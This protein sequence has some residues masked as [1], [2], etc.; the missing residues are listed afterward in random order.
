MF[1]EW[2]EQNRIEDFDFSTRIFPKISERKFWQND[3]L[4][5]HIELAENYLDFNWPAIKATDYIAFKTEKSRLHHENIYFE[6]RCA[7]HTLFL[8]EVAEYKGRFLPQIV[9]GI[10]AICE[11]TYWGVSAHFPPANFR[12]NIPAPDD[13]Y[14]DLFAAETAASLAVA[15]HTLYDELY[16]YCPEILT[17]IEYEL[18]RRI[19][20]S[21][22]TH[23]DWFWMGYN[24]P[25]NNWNPWIISNLLTVFLLVEKSS[26]VKYEGLKK[27]FFEIDC[28]YNSYTD[29]G[30]CDEGPT[31]WAQSPGA[32]AHFC[33]QLYQT[34]EG[35]INFFDD[36]K[37]R[38][39]AQYP[40]NVYIGDGYCVNYADGSPRMTGG[41]NHPIA[42]YIYGAR[43]NDKNLLNFTG[44]L[45]KMGSSDAKT[46]NRTANLRNLLYKALNFDDMC[47]E[48]EFVPKKTCLLPD[49][50]NSF[51]RAGKWYYSAKGGHNA[52]RHNHNDIANFIVY[53]DSE[54]LL[55]DA[56]APT[57]TAITFTDKRYTLWP[58]KSDWHNTPT[59]NG[60]VQE[61]GSEFRADSFSLDDNRT[62]ISFAKAYSEKAGLKTANRSIN[63]TDNGITIKDSFEFSKN[64]NTVF[65]SFITHRRVEITEKGA[66]IDGEFLLSSNIGKFSCD[67][68]SLKDDPRLFEAWKTEKLNRIKITF[69]AE[70]SADI[71]IKVS[72]I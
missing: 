48:Y 5:S 59:I 16:D 2:L 51:V 50:Q 8:G 39:I 60:F 23:R 69:N 38:A 49:L 24:I 28:I 1:R 61:H 43:Q 70:Y 36:D 27:M 53:Y 46:Y 13:G 17:R 33:E 44:C 47:Q 30:G 37:V 72:K 67:D 7:F 54:P 12:H 40:V 29:D 41:G 63:M 52:E 34:T 3:Y 22:L 31:Y 68:V 64:D 42:T 9:N 45:T 56:G 19:I 6:R 57:Y 11:E 71:E 15:Y 14:I 32:F 62:D 65:E 18:N 26:T 4:K 58:M 10:F 21:Y 55:I 35:K 20:K 25:I 66:L